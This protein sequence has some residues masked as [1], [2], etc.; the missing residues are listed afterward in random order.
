MRSD[1]VKKKGRSPDYRLKSLN[2]VTEASAKVG[3]AW[4]NE[5]GTITVVLD[6][7]AIVLGCPEVLLTLFPSHDS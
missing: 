3:A 7:G 6:P 2:K 4:I 5:D 1:E